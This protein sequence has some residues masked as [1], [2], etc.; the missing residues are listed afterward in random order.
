M[1]RTRGQDW[2]QSESEAAPNSQGQNMDIESSSS[3]DDFCLE[4]GN[5]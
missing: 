1:V 5:V 3:S 2:G 4:I